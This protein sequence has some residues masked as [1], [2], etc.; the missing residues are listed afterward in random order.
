[1]KFANMGSLDRILRFIVG[2]GLVAAVFLGKLDIGAPI[3]MAATAI[4]AV[5]ILTAVIAFCPL[6]APFGIR[7][8]PK[9]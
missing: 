5:F 6:Y 7:T 9:S 3:G 8:K 2:A 1:M 4:G